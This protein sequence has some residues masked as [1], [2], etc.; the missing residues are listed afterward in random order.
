MVGPDTGGTQASERIDV[1]T[2]T[3]QISATCKVLGSLSHLFGCAVFWE[4]KLHE[5][6]LDCGML[7]LFGDYFSFFLESL[8]CED[9]L[10]RLNPAVELSWMDSRTTV[11]DDTTR[12]VRSCV[13]G[14]AE[15]F[16]QSNDQNERI[17][18]AIYPQHQKPDETFF[19]VLSTLLALGVPNLT[20]L[21][22]SIVTKILKWGDTCVPTLLKSGLIEALFQGATTEDIGN[23]CMEREIIK[24]AY[25]VLLKGRTK[26]C[27][28]HCLPHMIDRD[29][30][31]RLHSLLA[32]S[33][34]V[35][36]MEN[37]SQKRTKEWTKELE[38]LQYLCSEYEDLMTTSGIMSL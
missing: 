19:Y 11:K 2:L 27:S 26:N 12:V 20:Q 21:A 1:L 3:P 24:I 14:I 23:E 22:T 28:E 15:A 32:Q 31:H 16:E 30:A 13:D 8:E 25:R 18:T 17:F 29:S 6:V 38:T 5:T 33:K 35:E 7:R 4:D 37:R 36:T 34:F 10:K 9:H